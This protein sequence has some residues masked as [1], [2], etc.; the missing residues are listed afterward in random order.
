MLSLMLCAAGGIGAG[1]S[2][3]F[4]GSLLGLGVYGELCHVDPALIRSALSPR[5]ARGFNNGSRMANY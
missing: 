2:T 3:T 1:R 4:P 5:A